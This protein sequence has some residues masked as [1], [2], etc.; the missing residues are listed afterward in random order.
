MSGIIQHTNTKTDESESCSVAQEKNS[1]SEQATVM[2]CLSG[3]NSSMLAASKEST[4]QSSEMNRRAKA[5]NS[6]DRR[7]LVLLRAG[8][9]KGITPT[10]IQRECGAKI[11]DFVS[12]W[13]DGENA[14]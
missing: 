9:V 8:L 12:S 2:L 5:Q 11:P 13:Q 7:M 6:Y 14:E 1:S 4:A 10:S 3:E